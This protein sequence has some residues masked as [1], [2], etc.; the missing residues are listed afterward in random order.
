MSDVDRRARI[1]G[2][3]AGLLVGGLAPLLVSP[4][5]ACLLVPQFTPVFAGFG[6]DLPSPTRF[7]LRYHP[8]GFALAL[9][10]VAVWQLWPLPET[11]GVAALVFGIVLTAALW[12]ACVYWLYAPIFRLG[13][14]IG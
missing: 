10:V 5:L 6:N 12:C 9:L 14:A 3:D 8:Y 11:R 4:V 2:S 7:I 13:A 1:N